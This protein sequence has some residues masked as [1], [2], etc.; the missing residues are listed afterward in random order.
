MNNLN[1]NIIKIL[2]VLIILTILNVLM[3]YILSK[4]DIISFKNNYFIVKESSI[5]CKKGI[6]FN[7]CTVAYFGDNNKSC[8][9]NKWF[10]IKPPK[11][12]NKVYYH[13]KDCNMSIFGTSNEIRFDPVRFENFTIVNAIFTFFIVIDTIIILN[14]LLY[15]LYFIRLRLKFNYF[16]THTGLLVPNIIVKEKK[17]HISYN[18]IKF[19][20]KLP[21]DKTIKIKA[22]IYHSNDINNVD[23]IIDE[24]HPKRRIILPRIDPADLKDI[25]CEIKGF[26]D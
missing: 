17:T 26:N 3:I 14:L 15:V 13:S 19:D 1:K 23:M 5:E 12:N 2:I 11:N 7:N 16:K 8:Y 9:I 22:I 24:N 25:K 4:T 21:N 6:I 18:K 10:L 20:Y